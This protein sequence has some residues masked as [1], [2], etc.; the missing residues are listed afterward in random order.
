MR[1]KSQINANPQYQVFNSRLEDLQKQ[2]LEL[3]SQIQHLRNPIGIEQNYPITLRFVDVKPVANVFRWHIEVQING[4]VDGQI[5]L[6]TDQGR[7][8]LVTESNT[9]IEIPKTEA[10]HDRMLVTAVSSANNK[11]SETLSIQ[12]K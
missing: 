6:V 1:A 10:I 2:K 4:A 12:I 5:F 9:C 3:D 11:L 8:V 7:K